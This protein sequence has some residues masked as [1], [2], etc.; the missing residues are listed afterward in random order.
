[1]FN[2]FARIASAPVSPHLQQVRKLRETVDTRLRG[3][4][5]A[6]VAIES[7]T[8][9]EPLT[10]W[11]QRGRE[12]SCFTYLV[13]DGQV[14]QGDLKFNQRIVTGGTFTLEIFEAWKRVDSVKLRL[15]PGFDAS[16]ILDLLESVRAIRT[17]LRQVSKPASDQER[18]IEMVIKIVE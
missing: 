6:A 10:V 18:T 3:F 12:G 8:K 5:L 15:R 11:M 7:V 16:K 2:P 17:E 13:T 9:T 14:T 1:M 4:G